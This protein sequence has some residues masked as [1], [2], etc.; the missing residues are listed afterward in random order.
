MSKSHI[1]Y[2]A[3]VLQF[4]LISQ[5][6]VLGRLIPTI[7]PPR[8]SYIIREYIINHPVIFF[9]KEEGRWIREGNVS[10]TGN[11]HIYYK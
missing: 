1:I 4:N 3:R 9:N 10:P 6:G 8:Y 7:L 2:Q 11:M 5:L